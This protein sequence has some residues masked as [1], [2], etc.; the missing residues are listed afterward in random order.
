MYCHSSL[1]RLQFRGSLSCNFHDFLSGI[2]FWGSWTWGQ[3]MCLTIESGADQPIKSNSAITFDKV[4]TLGTFTIGES[5]VDVSHANTTGEIKIKPMLERHHGGEEQFFFLSVRASRYPR[6]AT[7]FPRS[8]RIF[9][10]VNGKVPLRGFVTQYKKY[11]GGVE[12]EKAHRVV[13]ISTDKVMKP[14]LVK[15]FF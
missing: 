7:V 8:G 9:L 2:V 4:S 6:D 3:Q 10:L 11:S 1:K 12:R 14:F 5:F 13:G 15:L